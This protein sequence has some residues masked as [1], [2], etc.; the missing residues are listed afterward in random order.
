[1]K[2]LKITLAA[3]SLGAVSAASAHSLWTLGEN[4]DVFEA[5]LIYG[6]HFPAPEKIAEERL[7]LFEPLQVLSENGKITLQ[8]KGENYHYVHTQ[9]LG[10]GT[11]ILLATY[12]PTY[13]TEKDDGKWEMGKTRAD[14]PTA[15]SCGLYAMQGKSFVIIDDS[16]EFAVKP[17]GDGY[18][19]TP[20]V[21]PHDIKANELTKFKVT[22]NGQPLK[23]VEVL[24]A[25][26]GFD[27]NELEIHAF[28]AK[29]DE[30]GEF[31]FKAL[32][33]GDW[34]LSAEVENKGDDPKTCEKVVNEFTLSFRVK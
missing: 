34:Y 29:T 1:M 5:D 28:R 13:W 17:T 8:Q 3:L 30:K 10:K 6:H 18:E 20:T 24:G 23:D 12:K 27:P 26:G 33:A 21:N 22:L 11:H 4:K 15:K 25:P 14:Y 16:G 7:V 2:N 32:S 9:K 31:N 19:I